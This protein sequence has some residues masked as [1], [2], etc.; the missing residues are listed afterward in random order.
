[1]ESGFVS[2]TESAALSLLRLG[3]TFTLQRRNFHPGPFTNKG[4][5]EVLGNYHPNLMYLYFKGPP[6]SI[7]FCFPKPFQTCFAWVLSKG[8]M[9]DV[10]AESSAFIQE[11]GVQYQP[12]SGDSPLSP[13]KIPWGTHKTRR[14]C[15]LFL[16]TM[17]SFAFIS[18][19]CRQMWDLTIP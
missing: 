2:P 3:G 14:Q 5:R 12:L 7:C 17:F 6:T 11:P 16:K 4:T 8:K 19:L 18:C 9:Q 15:N 10:S 13:R 1:M